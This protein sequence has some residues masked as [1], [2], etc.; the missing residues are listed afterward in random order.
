MNEEQEP[1]EELQA[2]LDAVLD[3]ALDDLDDGDDDMEDD[4]PKKAELPTRATAKRSADEAVEEDDNALEEDFGALN[5]MMK[6]LMGAGAGDTD[7]VMGAFM[8]ELQGQ[9]ASELQNA[10]NAGEP[11]TSTA[12]SRNESDDSRSEVDRTI[13]KLLEEMTSATNQEASSGGDGLDNM[14]NELGGDLSADD[15]IDGMMAQLLSKELMYEPMK[16]VTDKFPEWLE[17]KKN[18]L[19]EDEYKRYDW[20]FLVWL[21]LLGTPL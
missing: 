9:I 21:F 14:M 19:P 15:M 17:G 13:S 5:D 1:E 6:N 8:K 7:E 10:S 4:E 12:S 11:D 16:Q 2:R 3:S 18:A 20:I